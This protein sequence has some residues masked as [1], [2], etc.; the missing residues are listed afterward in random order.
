MPQLQ[1]YCLCQTVVC[2]SG[3][4]WEDHQSTPDSSSNTAWYSVNCVICIQSKEWMF[5]Q[6]EAFIQ[7]KML[8]AIFML[9]VEHRVWLVGTGWS[10]LR[11]MSYVGASNQHLGLAALFSTTLSTYSNKKM[12]PVHLNSLKGNAY[13]FQWMLFLQQSF[14]QT[15]M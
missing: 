12:L 4:C 13:I 7:V 9:Q 6:V 3:W 15:K 1:S 14:D 2:H 11:V 10:A 8:S 5:V